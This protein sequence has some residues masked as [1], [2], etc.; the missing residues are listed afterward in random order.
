[1]AQL[2]DLAQGAT[3][4]G[5]VAAPVEIERAVPFS[6]RLLFV[7]YRGTDGTAGCDFVDESFARKLIVRDPP[8]T[9]Y[10]YP[11]GVA[12]LFSTRDELFAPLA[13]AR[14]RR[15]LHSVAQA[16]IA[17]VA[18]R[19]SGSFATVSEIHAT[20]GARNDALSVGPA[21]EILWEVFGTRA[22]IEED[23]RKLERAE[24]T[25]RITV[26]VVADKEIDADLFDSFARKVQGSSINAWFRLTDLMVNGAFADV[27]SRL[28]RATCK[29]TSA[30]GAGD[31]LSFVALGLERD[32]RQWVAVKEIPFGF[33]GIAGD[34]REPLEDPVFWVDLRNRGS[35]EARIDGAFINVRFRDI[36]LHGIPEPRLLRPLTT[37]VLPL[38]DGELGYRE[39][40]LDAPVLVPPGQHVRLLVRLDDSGFAWRG[41]VEIGFLYG[42]EQKRTCRVPALTILL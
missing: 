13:R 31:E 41:E 19:L 36:K 22:R 29:S 37:V 9:G 39:V 3:V 30:T 23:L 42:S 33:S 27:V 11:A 32:L 7:R 14:E 35:R 5:L 28:D 12:H 6:E 15:V 1:M 10:R 20:A 34:H 38:N 24:R 21:T 17:E 18:Q 25:G 4:H 16:Y 26:A 2:N 8:L 40:E